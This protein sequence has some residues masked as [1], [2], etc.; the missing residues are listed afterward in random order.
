MKL[1]SLDN[2]TRD[3]KLVV[4][5]DDLIWYAEALGIAPSLQAAL[6]NWRQVEPQLRALSD[7]LA[8]QCPKVSDQ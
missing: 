8:L 7:Q 4:V 5:S 2:G 1:A 3:G 6:D